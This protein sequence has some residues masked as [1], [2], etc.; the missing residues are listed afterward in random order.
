[1]CIYHELHDIVVDVLAV[2]IQMKT[3]TFYTGKP[4]TRVGTKQIFPVQEI[5]S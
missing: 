3:K 2:I 1:M 4:L 5:V